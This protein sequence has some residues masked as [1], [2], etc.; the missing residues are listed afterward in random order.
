MTPFDKAWQSGRWV[1]KCTNDLTI[2]ISRPPSVLS[3]VMWTQE[4]YVQK[5]ELCV[6]YQ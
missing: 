5:L 1:A 4:A 2:K 6:L 3:T